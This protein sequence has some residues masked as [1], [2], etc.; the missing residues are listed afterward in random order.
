MPC[1]KQMRRA[2]E[3]LEQL[4]PPRLAAEPPSPEQGQAFKDAD[5]GVI[6][7]RDGDQWLATQ[8][9]PQPVPVSERLP[10]PGDCDAGGAV[11]DLGHRYLEA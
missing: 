4:S 6:Y 2:A 9:V 1:V 5:T 7:V 10:G 11:L 8:P 3:L